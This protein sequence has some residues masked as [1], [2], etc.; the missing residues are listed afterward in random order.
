MD[1][2]KIRFKKIGRRSE[3]YI[4]LT[5]IALCIAV[6]LRS[7]QFLTSNNIVDILR[8]LIVPAMFVMGELLVIISGGFDLSFPA[9]AALSYSLTTT[10]LVNSN[11]TGSALLPFVM[12]I[13]IGLVLGSL[14]GLLISYF[15]LPAMIVTLGTMAVFRSLML[16]VF[17]L[18]EITILLPQGMKDFG[19]MNLFEVVN[20]VNKLHSTMPVTIFFM[21]IM[22]A[23]IYLLLRF[24]LFGR[25]L[26][27]IGGNE[28]SAMRA[29]IKVKRNKFLLYCLVGAMAG[30]SGMVR[31]C[32][33]Q[34][35]IPSALFGMEMTVISA[36]ILGGAS[37]F[38]GI[39]TITG[40]LLGI[41]LVV[42]VQNSMS[43]LGIPTF[44]QDFFMG[45]L[46]LT[47]ITLSAVQVNR[48]KK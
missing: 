40:S 37:I 30:M 13:T 34:Q 27:A 6:Q 2:L 22:V 42:T 24:T 7:G 26:Y 33:A 11:Y 18:R 9:V 20:P 16:G 35:A 15:R 12:A 23:S 28:V 32:M 14:N 48:R 17:D 29:G 8:A 5:L 46:I 38:G 1:A 19:M 36:I 39:G 25:S 3:F 44:W 4:L 10:I 31:V 45:F 47:G 21:I 43:L 41:S